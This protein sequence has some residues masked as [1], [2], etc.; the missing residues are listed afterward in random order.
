MNK[1]SSY[2]RIV[3]FL[4]ETI[5]GKIS[6]KLADSG[7]TAHVAPT[8]PDAFDALRSEDVSFAITTRA[9]ID[10]IRRIRAIPVLNLE[11]FFHSSSSNSAARHF[12]TKAFLERVQFLTRSRSSLTDHCAHAAGAA[13]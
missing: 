5:A 1:D 4:P 10:M 3:I 8:A 11:I 7:Y 2:A 9:Y 12:D 13:C 6:K